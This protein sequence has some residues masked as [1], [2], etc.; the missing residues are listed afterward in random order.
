MPT[1][2]RWRSAIAV[3]QQQPWDRRDCAARCR[4]SDVTLSSRWR[5][6]ARAA[7]GAVCGAPLC[8]SHLLRL[9]ALSAFTPAAF[10]RLRFST[11]GACGARESGWR[12]MLQTAPRAISRAAMPLSAAA[13]R[14]RAAARVR[15]CT[16]RTQATRALTR[17]LFSAPRVRQAFPFAPCTYFP[18][19]SVSQTNKMPS[20]N[21]SADN[22]RHVFPQPATARAQPR[23]ARRRRRPEPPWPL[24]GHSGQTFRRQNWRWR[25]PAPV[26]G[27]PDARAR[28]A[29]AR[30]A[31]RAR[32]TMARLARSAA[33]RHPVVAPCRRGWLAV[34]SLSAVS[35]L[36]CV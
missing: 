14:P 9:D 26:A 36:C 19:P 7:C 12:R 22:T 29:A 13:A 25:E 17:V 11:P 31:A 6:D 23:R 4:V 5:A 27:A 20:F 15:T 34:M 2:Q 32:L 28:R 30:A 24:G 8:T 21:T 1:W 35:Q 33:R 16:R 3:L 10:V 18:F